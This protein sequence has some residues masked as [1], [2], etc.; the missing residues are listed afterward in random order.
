VT[1]TARVRRPPPPFRVVEVAGTAPIGPRLTRVTL[2]GPALV[3]FPTPEPAASVRLLLP[4][5]GDPGLVLP[6]WTGNEFLRADGARPVLRTFTPLDLDADRGRL[7]LAVVRHDGGQ[8]SAWVGTAGPGTPC[9]ISGPGRGYAIDPDADGYVLAGDESA[10]PAIGQLLEVLPAGVP[11]RVHVE[12]AAPEGRIPLPAH[13]C[14]T[15]TWHDLTDPAD[16]GSALVAAVT[17]LDVADDERVWVAGE[18][19]SVQRIRVHLFTERG[20]PRSRAT[21][22]GYWKRGRAGDGDD[23]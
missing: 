12:V 7:D 16:P 21:V 15:V 18:A 5:P 23:D 6:D 13:P 11:V 10:I 14:A 8:A 4:S 17:A 1:T 20:F 3:G 22:R 9:A 2:T 19:A